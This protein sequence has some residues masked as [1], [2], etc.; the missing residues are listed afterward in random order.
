MKCELY[1]K[2]SQAP[3]NWCFLIVV[4]EKTFESPLDYKEIQPLNPQGN[5]SWIFTGKT[6][7]EAEGVLL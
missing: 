4:L 7:A 6:D 2:E 3:K 5:Q 1:H